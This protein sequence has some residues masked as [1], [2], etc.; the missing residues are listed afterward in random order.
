ML[1]LSGCHSGNK[2]SATQSADITKF[3][4]LL[5]IF[6]TVKFPFR[7]NADSLQKKIPDSLALSIKAIHRFFPASVF[8]KDFGRDEKLAYYP[9]GEIQSDKLNYVF[10]KVVGTDMRIAYLCLFDREGKYLNKLVLA[11]TNSQQ[12]GNKTEGS[13]DTKL[14]IT[15]NQQHAVS[16]SHNI[17][18]ENVYTANPD[19]TF[20]LV[21]TNSSEPMNLSEVYNPIGNMPHKHRYSADYI[22]GRTGMVSVRDGK[23]PKSFRFFIHFYD[24]DTNCSGEIDGTGKFVKSD[25][26]QYKE[27]GGPCA[28]DFH[29][30]NSSVTIQE[31]GGCGAYRGINCFFDGTFKKKVAPVK[32]SKRHHA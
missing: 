18:R 3:S 5:E 8:S 11:A 15:I 16:S 23:D 12:P 4:N 25:Y 21:L 19:G 28:I 1:V 32:K 26:G 14:I 6:P 24:D 29:F 2:E 10:L 31:V 27:D 22:Y 30:T 13:I 20:T 7:M 17:T 9:L